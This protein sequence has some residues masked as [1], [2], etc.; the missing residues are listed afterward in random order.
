MPIS[1]NAYSGAFV[2]QPIAYYWWLEMDATV[3]EETHTIDTH[4]SI[5]SLSVPCIAIFSGTNVSAAAAGPRVSIGTNA[6]D[7]DN[8][9]SLTDLTEIKADFDYVVKYITNKVVPVA[10]DTPLTLRVRS[11][12]SVESFTLKCSLVC[13]PIP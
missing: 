1:I 5:G 10:Y 13:L 8:V 3:D 7:Y 9:V 6:P 11:P 4:D 2:N 12:R